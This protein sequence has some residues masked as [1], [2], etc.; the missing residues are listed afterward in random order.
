MNHPPI[1]TPS[2]K[3]ALETLERFV[4]RVPQYAQRRNFVTPTLSEVSCLSPYIRLRL[5][6]EEEVLAA[7]LSQHRFG[8]AEK[9]I[10]EV[11]WRSYWRNWLELNSAVWCGYE[12]TLAAFADK[13]DPQVTAVCEAASKIPT[14]NHWVE[15]L[16]RT[17]YLHNHIRMYFASIWIHTLKLPWALGA[18]FFMQH[19]YD[20]DPASNTLSWRWVAGLHTVGKTYLAKAENI[21]FHTG[22]RFDSGGISLATS[23]AAIDDFI[24]EDK[25]P[26]I[27]CDLIEYSDTP[28]IIVASD[29]ELSLETVIPRQ[30]LMRSQVIF[31]P[32]ELSVAPA[33]K[34]F[35]AEAL[36]DAIARLTHAGAKVAV[37]SQTAAE[38]NTLQVTPE[39]SCLVCLPAIG[40]SRHSVVMATHQIF[41]VERSIRY[42]RHRWDLSAQFPRATGFFPYW[43]HIR[44]V[45]EK[46]YAGSLA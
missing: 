7:V 15:E 31:V 36:S 2:R 4:E 13:K 44:K 21:E 10:Q 12:Q 35:R 28:Y 22:K 32:T 19:L 42:T 41:G 43:N 34:A 38:D 33:V 20:G 18:E 39:A 46:R 29:E 1:F 8:A 23:P 25:E 9:F 11:C 24:P 6:S 37:Y 45:L 30:A 27:A 40:K 17:G 3:A 16:T 5:I 14:L 26:M